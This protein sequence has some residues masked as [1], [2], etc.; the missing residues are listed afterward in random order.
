MNDIQMRR[1]TYISLSLLLQRPGKELLELVSGSEFQELWR[2]VESTYS[3]QFPKSWRIEAL[4]ALKEWDR[5]WNIT[6][7]PVKPLTEPIESL[8]KVWTRDQS[9]EAPIANQKGYLKS[10]WACH[11]EELLTQIGFEIPLQFAHC[12]DHLILE[13]EFASLLVEAASIEA[14]IKFAEHH[15]DWLEDL[16]EDSKNKN[17]PEMY[18]DLYYLCLQY[19]RADILHLN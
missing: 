12:P 5:M 11:M 13:L 2:Q 18:Q 19:V 4:P 17:V 8:Y 6:M 9:C 14:Q 10:D 3:I 16:F 7:G 1:Q 15:F